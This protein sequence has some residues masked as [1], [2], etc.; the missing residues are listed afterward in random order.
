MI[1][2]ARA[3]VHL[4]KNTKMSPEKVGVHVH[5]RLREVLLS[6]YRHVPYYR[7]LMKNIGY[8]PFSDYSGPE[9]LSHFPVTT[10]KDI[11][12]YGI[13]GFT[14]EGCDLSNCFSDLTSGSTGIPLTVYR[15]LR[16]LDQHQQIYQYR[17][18]QKTK[19]FFQVFIAA[20][21]EYFEKIREPILSAL[22]ISPRS[23]DLK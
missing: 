6:A 18:I 10:K 14:K 22:R 12:Q 11:K 2:H 3:A 19:T 4:I 8:N 23:A 1:S 7:D 15:D 16:I 5:Q 9:D 13:Q 21:A 17:N 20:K